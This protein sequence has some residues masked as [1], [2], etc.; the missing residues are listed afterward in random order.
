[1]DDQ[2]PHLH[3]AT[4]VTSAELSTLHGTELRIPPTPPPASP[5][6][7]IERKCETAYAIVTAQ[8]PETWPRVTVAQWD[9]MNRLC[10]LWPRAAD[11]QLG[12]SRAKITILKC[13]PTPKRRRQQAGKERRTVL[14]AEGRCIGFGGA[15]CNISKTRTGNSQSIQNGRRKN[16]LIDFFATTGR[17]PGKF[18]YGP[19]HT[20]NHVSQ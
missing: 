2:D 9:K 17:I 13:C 1:M 20:H 14:S 11:S 16:V 12:P 7:R 10:Y 15:K 18:F 19:F 3:R 8:R 5:S 6:C 4:D